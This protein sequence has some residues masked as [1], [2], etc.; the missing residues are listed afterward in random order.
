MLD[1]RRSVASACALSAPAGY[2]DGIDFLRLG[3]LL[4]SFMSGKWFAA[5]AAL[6]LC[7]IVAMTTHRW[8]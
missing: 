2:V 3:G 6:W 7:T 1:P 8:H 5:G 4:V